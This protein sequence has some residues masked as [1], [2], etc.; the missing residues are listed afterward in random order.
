MFRWCSYC[1]IFIGESAPFDSYELTHGICS[2]CK[3]AQAHRNAAGVKS[4][5]VIRDFFAGIWEKAK[6]GEPLD[7]E[8]ILAQS[9]KLGIK[10][11]DLFM[12]MIQPILW[13][14]G[15]QFAAGKITVAKEH[16]F[17]EFAEKILN[18]SATKAEA[19][20]TT[21]QQENH[22]DILLCC[23]DQNY[24]SNRFHLRFSYRL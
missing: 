6:T 1:Q 17:T 7:C 5:G 4:I 21:R 18:L 20:A 13:E 19:H 14:I 11:F 12:G 24:H 8:K 22:C 9:Q 3:S 2:K 15:V 10:D 16:L 23:I